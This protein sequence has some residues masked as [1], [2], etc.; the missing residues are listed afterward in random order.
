M[1]PITFTARRAFLFYCALTALLFGRS[2]TYEFVYDDDWRIYRNPA[3]QQLLPLSAY[4]LNPSTQ[5]GRT[6]EGHTY[7]PLP[8]LVFALTHTTVGMKALCYRLQ[9]LFLHSLN[10]TLVC[11]V[12]IQILEL[13]GAAALLAGALFLIHPLQVETVVW[14]SELSNVLVFTWILCGVLAWQ[15]YR[16]T[17]SHSIRNRHIC[18]RVARFYDARK[19]RLPGCVVADS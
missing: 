3:V 4:F 13:G 15:R 12:G 19:Q 7:R 11:I 18:F 16:E 10:A 2:L 1:T 5:A 9:N 17:G 14:V 6:L 8:T